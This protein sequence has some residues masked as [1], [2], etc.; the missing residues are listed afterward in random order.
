MRFLKTVTPIIIYFFA[1]AAVLAEENSNRN[2]S[3]W[4]GMKKGCDAFSIPGL[5]DFIGD[6][7]KWN[8]ELPARIQ[9]IRTYSA[10]TCPEY[11]AKPNG[12][13]IAE[14]VKATDT[15]IT[16]TI[17]FEIQSQKLKGFLDK[18][19]DDLNVMLADTGFFFTDFDCGKQFWNGRNFISA[20]I[21]RM[22]AELEKGK[23]TCPAISNQLEAQA[24]AARSAELAKQR[25]QA[26]PGSAAP[27]VK[28]APSHQAPSD[29]TGIPEEQ[30]KQNQ[31]K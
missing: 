6:A 28:G 16:A 24:K 19:H 8:I 9:A 15:F 21:D 4:E 27:D 31:K 2:P 1:G 25:A 26:G 22:K 29:I 23:E 5:K 7:K 18:N 3:N 14:F 10:K 20:G 11:L 17:G 12:D 30:G 13:A